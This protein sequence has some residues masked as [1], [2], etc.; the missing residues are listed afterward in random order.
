MKLQVLT[1]ELCK[2]WLNRIVMINH[3]LSVIGLDISPE[4]WII[5]PGEDS[6]HIKYT[7]TKVTRTG[8]QAYDMM[9]NYDY[10]KHVFINS[11]LT[12]YAL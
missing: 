2:L 8:T 11:L 9:C 4:V 12:E 5:L 6:K 10:E 3:G 1:E 7:L